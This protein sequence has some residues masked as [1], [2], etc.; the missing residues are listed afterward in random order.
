MAKYTEEFKQEAVRL[1]RSGNLGVAKTADSLGIAHETLRNWVKR[2]EI[3][4]VATQ[5][6][7]QEQLRQILKENARLKE[8][9]I[10]LK[11]AAVYLGQDHARLG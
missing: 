11:K 8:E 7:N 10:I 1:Y 2:F 9:N 4:D 5:A 3:V 6:V